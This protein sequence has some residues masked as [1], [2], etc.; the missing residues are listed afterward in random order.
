[1]IEAEF[2]AVR[3]EALEEAANPLGVY[4]RRQWEWSK[5]TFGPGRRTKGICQHITKEIAEV[6]AKPGDLSEWVDI[7]IL[8]MDG[9]WRHGGTPEQFMADMQAKQD[10]NFARTWPTPESEDVAVEHV[11]EDL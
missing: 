10:K 3:R 6:L 9:Y 4:L 2:R 1:M 5:R 11:R 7:A 8:A